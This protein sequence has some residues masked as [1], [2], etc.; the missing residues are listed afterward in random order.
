MEFRDGVG[1]CN[2]EKV[3]RSIG[4][5]VG[6]EISFYRILFD[7]KGFGCIHFESKDER[8]SE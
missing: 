4:E 2:N 6:S 1:W 5:F 7:G 8:E 3:E